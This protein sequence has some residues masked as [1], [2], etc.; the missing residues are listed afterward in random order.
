MS[1]YSFVIDLGFGDC[2][3]GITVDYL[4]SRSPDET[5]V[6]RFSGGH[7]VGHTVEVEGRMHTFSNFGAGS[8]R[9]VP[10]YYSQH[11][12]VFP[13]A[14]LA[15]YEVIADLHPKL[16]YHPLVKVCT[17]Y[18]V[19]FNRALEQ[20]NQHGSCGVGFGA[21]IER[22]EGPNKLF[23]T[24]LTNSFVLQQKLNAI[25]IYYLKRVKAYRNQQLLEMYL[26]ELEGYQEQRFI[27]QCIDSLDLCEIRRHDWIGTKHKHIIFEGSQ[28]ILLD[29][30]HGF[31]PHVTRS[32]TTCRNAM[33]ILSDI[34]GSGGEIDFYY[35]S[36]CYQNRHGNGPMSKEGDIGL[37]NNEKEANKTNA[38]QGAFR[39]GELDAQL[40]QYALT[41]D[42]LYRAKSNSKDHLVLTC[43]DQRPDF[44]PLA[45]LSENQMSIGNLIGSYSPDSK[46]F[47]L[48]RSTG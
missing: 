48:L 34:D 10:T 45:W 24:G 25:R 26:K 8:F 18:D 28:G 15:E 12:V 13:S 36:R 35:L 16:I 38:Y 1:K 23:A 33:R 21:C 46:D 3:K 22:N 6:V 39:V 37:V 19:A 7:Q 27:N 42:Q 17:A 30:D 5:V 44:D 40:L 31:F 14:M 20:F 43:L 11:C 4:A 2:G 29:Q 41:C 47:R 32:H 9:G